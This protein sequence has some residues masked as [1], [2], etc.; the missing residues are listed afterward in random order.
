MDWKQIVNSPWLGLIGLLSL[1]W[2]LPG[3][4]EDA[5]TWRKWFGDMN[6]GWF[7]LASGVGGTLTTL[8]LIVALSAHGRTILHSL[9][10]MFRNRRNVVSDDVTEI[11]TMSQTEYDELETKSPNTL[12]FITDR[13][14]VEGDGAAEI[15]ETAR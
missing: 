8:W 13:E 11:K 10:R 6:P 3:M 4:G 5:V 14:G 1:V 12:Y 7:W 15:G 9:R 2:G